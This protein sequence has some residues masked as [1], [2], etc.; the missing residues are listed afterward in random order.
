VLYLYKLIAA[1]KCPQQEPAGL[2]LDCDEKKIRLLPKKE[3]SHGRES[4][5]KKQ[6]MADKDGCFDLTGIS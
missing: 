5:N 4:E 3:V 1:F 6:Q 2:D